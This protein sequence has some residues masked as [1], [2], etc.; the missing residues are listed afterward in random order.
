M[1][2]IT[3]PGCG[4][5]VADWELHQQWHVDLGEFVRKLA[6]PDLSPEE[7]NE[8]GLQIHA[9]RSAV[10]EAERIIRKAQP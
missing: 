10:R 4:A 7:W 8:Q 3:C 9:E 5:A 6:A 2:T 1:F